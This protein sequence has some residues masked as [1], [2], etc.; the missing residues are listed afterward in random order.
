MTI[1]NYV[2]LKNNKDVV[3][4]KVEANNLKE[5]RQNI[6]G[7]GFLPTKIYEE[8]KAETDNK[9]EAKKLQVLGLQDRIDFTSTFQI[10]AQSG[11]PVIESLV[12]IEND[13]AKLKIRLLA[14][15]IRRQ[16][17][18]GL[19]FA[20]T[21]AKYPNIFGQIYI[22]L[23]RAGEDSGELELTL[24]R[25]LELLKKEQDIKAKVVKTLMYPAFVVILAMVIVTVMLVFVF[26]A[27]KDM[28]ENQG[29]EL[30]WITATLMSI[31][32]FLK[33]YW[34][35]IPIIFGTV[36][37]GTKFL[38]TWEPSKKKIDKYILNVP[39]LSD[40]I[41]YSNFS[42][43]IAVMQVAYDAG[44]PIVDCLYLSNLTL[45]NFTLR[46]K[47][48]TAT[49]KVQQGQHLSMAL[50][51]TQVMPKMILFMIATGEQSGRL[52]DMLVQATVF[53]DK[54]L[55][56]IIDT[57]TKMI[58]PIM[59]LVIGSIVLVLALSL[60]MPLFQSYTAN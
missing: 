23:V 20:D 56:N 16:I 7:L 52:G 42:N 38:L 4:G 10:L 41:Q 24:E 31:G 48:S 27:F 57:M 6:R 13:A 22:G 39:L 29:K 3:K 30:P 46:D 5:A 17:M 19:T 58:E 59:L 8:A 33:A 51:T 1:Y 43:F 26:P 21:I 55:D 28:F 15:E 32:E 53:I 35:I 60:Y 34:V 11:I 18:G 40:L 37:F 14:K 44:V 47:I 50:K 54:K 2:A 9:V 25:L 45:T 49:G 36:I 12:F